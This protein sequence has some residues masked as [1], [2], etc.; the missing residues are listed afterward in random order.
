MWLLESVFTIVAFRQRF[1]KIPGA[2]KGKGKKPLGF[3]RP[4]QPFNTALSQVKPFLRF[5]FLLVWSLKVGQHGN[6]GHQRPFLSMFPGLGMDTASLT[7]E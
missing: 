4:G 7:P 1:P 2:K 6:P 3:C 5:H